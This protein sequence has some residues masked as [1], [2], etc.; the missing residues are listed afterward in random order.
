[1]EDIEKLTLA[2]RCPAKLPVLSKCVVPSCLVT[3]SSLHAGVFA[4][5]ELQSSLTSIRFLLPAVAIWTWRLVGGWSQSE[6]ATAMRAGGDGVLP[7]AALC[8]VTS[9]R[10]ARQDLMNELNLERQA[11]EELQARRSQSHS[12][13]KY[14]I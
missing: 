3:A 2:S 11:A 13:V 12:L 6:D 10:L 7:S 8:P 14:M 1:M 4:H 9:S 5:Y